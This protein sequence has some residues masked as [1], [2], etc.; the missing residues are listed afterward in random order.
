MGLRLK[1]QE[2][3][4]HGLAWAAFV[5]AIIG[6]VTA[7]ASW[8][9]ALVAAVVGIFWWWMPFVLV[10]VLGLVV[11]G[12]VIVDGIP[13]RTAIYGV[14]VWPSC[15]V[16]VQG[17]LGETV[18]GWVTDLNRWL[19]A[20]IAEWITDVPRGSAAL[21]TGISVAAI[22]FAVVYTRRYDATAAARKGKTPARPGTAPAAAPAE[23]RLQL[24]TRG[25]GTGKR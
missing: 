7:T 24:P 23:G 13:N 3:T 19:D 20:E 6:G 4:W 22:A 9:G 12:D 5:L 15:V 18:R 25:R 10:T 1:A 16:A 11:V 17:R 14:M 8:V 21:L 2:G